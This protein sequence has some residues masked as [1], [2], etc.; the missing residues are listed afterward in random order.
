MEA[1][2]VAGL[3]RLCVSFHIRLAVQADPRVTLLSHPAINVLFPY[4]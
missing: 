2:T 4:L 1:L 3:E